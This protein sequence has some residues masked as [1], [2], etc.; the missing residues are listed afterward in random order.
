MKAL[1]AAIPPLEQMPQ[2]LEVYTEEED[3]EEE[4]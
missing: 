4:M 3:C 1:S 2:M